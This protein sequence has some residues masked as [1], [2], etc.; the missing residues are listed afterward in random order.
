MK[1]F[2]SIVLLLAAAATQVATLPAVEAPYNQIRAKADEAHEIY[3]RVPKNKGEFFFES[4]IQ[5][6]F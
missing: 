2:G 5:Y 4:L 3:A 1:N 6:L